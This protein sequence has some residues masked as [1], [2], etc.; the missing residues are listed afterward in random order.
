MSIFVVAI[1]GS[2]ALSFTVKSKNKLVHHGMS[3]VI[4]AVNDNIGYRFTVL[5]RKIIEN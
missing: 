5:A 2:S 1:R 4:H 3:V